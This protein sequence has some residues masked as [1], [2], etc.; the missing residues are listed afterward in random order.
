MNEKLIERKLRY[1]VERLGGMAI[2]L[3]AFLFTGLPDRMILM[4][5]GRIYFAEIKTTGKQLSPRQVIVHGMLQR[6]GF[7]VYVIDTQEKLD[8]FIKIITPNEV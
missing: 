3:L 5:G 7:Y 2:K 1:A 6:L 8:Q 4:P